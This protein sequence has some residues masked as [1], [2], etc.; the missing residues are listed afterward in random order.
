MTSRLIC[1]AFFYINIYPV[2]ITESLIIKTI[3]ITIL[4]NIMQVE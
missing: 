3:F 1:Q 4:D 2:L